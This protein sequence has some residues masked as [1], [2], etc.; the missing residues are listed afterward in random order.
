MVL[1][2]CQK[3]RQIFE[4]RIYYIST[5][6]IVNTQLCILQKANNLQHYA[7]PLLLLLQE[8]A[9]QEK[10]KEDQQA[11]ID[12]HKLLSRSESIST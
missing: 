4:Y 5:F 10:H 11:S 3:S 7:I 2:T 6:S 12:K 1:I 9:T 8:V